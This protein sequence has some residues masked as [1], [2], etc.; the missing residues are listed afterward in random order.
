MRQRVDKSYQ[1][2]EWVRNR[3]FGQLTRVYVG[4]AATEEKVKSSELNQ[5]R[6]I[7]FATHGVVNKK[8][9]SLSG[10][11]FGHETET[12]D[13]VLY[14]GEIY[15]LKLNADLAVLS[16]CETASGKWVEGEGLISFARG[17]LYAG[18]RN[19]LVSL[20]KVSD[21]STS[22]VMKEFYQGLLDGKS[23]AEALKEAKEKMIASEYDLA[24][25]YY[26]AP[27]VLIG[28]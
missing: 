27:F 26:W 14:L 22:N 25:P 6:Y 11:V 17:F 8:L 4:E 7:H 2:V 10:L 19:L 13:G 16:A 18:A 23:M 15:N 20:W 3:W 5:S 12:E 21:I 24:M 1:G 9:P 28:K